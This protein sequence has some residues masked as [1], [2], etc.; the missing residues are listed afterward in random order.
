MT[1]QPQYVGQVII[2]RGFATAEAARNW[3][4]LMEYRVQRG[5]RSQ[6]IHMEKH[7]WEPVTGGA[8]KVEG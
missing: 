1:Q 5:S 8:K 6:N 3:M 7:L 4:N 2:E